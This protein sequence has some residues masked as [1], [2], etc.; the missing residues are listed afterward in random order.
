MEK[1]KLKVVSGKN[2]FWWNMMGSLCNAASSVFLLLAVSRISG[3][4]TAGVFSIAYAIA[5]LMLTIGL[6]EVRP[7]QSTDIQ[8]K[9][10][11]K[12]YYTFRI[13]TCLLMIFI[14][15]IYTLSKGYDISKTIIV[16]LMCVYKMIDALGDVFQGMFQQKNHLE[17]SGKSLAFRVILS[18]IFFCV[19]LYFY[20][21]LLLATV[22]AI[23]VS[24][25]W[26]F[27]YDWQY[28]KKYFDKAEWSFMFE[29]QKR[30]FIEC[31]PLFLGSFMMMYIINA[32]KYAID[33]YLSSEFQAYYN[34]IFMPASVV[35]LFSL[36]LFRPMLVTLTE[37]WNDFEYKKFITIIIKLTLSIC[38]VTAVVLLAVN[39]Y[40]IPILSWV[41]GMNLTDYHNSLLLVIFGGGLSALSTMLYY[42]I[43]VMRQQYSLLIGYVISCLASVFLANL[44]VQSY[45]ILG[46]AIT[47]VLAMVI[48]S[49]SFLFIF[50]HYYRKRST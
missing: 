6:F 11:F 36:F 37:F 19:F 39:F 33:T 24:V 45:G 44:F 49:L 20:D 42:I 13:I 21:D 1:I 25:F 4:A 35:N 18:T 41:Y 14:S 7:Y 50:L 5:Q 10:L 31:F 47:Y 17:L 30:L 28:A 15:I 43:T 48:L 9:F 3:D 22:V 23:I 8:E 16:I 38:I 34:V 40:G 46:G 26:F 12:D 2:I 29:K 32:P 27:F